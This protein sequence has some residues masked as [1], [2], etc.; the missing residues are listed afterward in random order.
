VRLA[1]EDT[2]VKVEFG[3]G[4][5]RVTAEGEMSLVTTAW[6]PGTLLMEAVVDGEALSAQIEVTRPWAHH[7][8]EIFAGDGFRN[9][10]TGAPPSPAVASFLG[11]RQAPGRDSREREGS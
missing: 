8:P 4:T 2:L 7:R 11:D 1:G 9:G 10:R 5:Y 3:H 6:A